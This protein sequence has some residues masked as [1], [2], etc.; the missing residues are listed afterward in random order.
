MS[1]N[2]PWLNPYQRSYQSIKQTLIEK[3]QTRVPEITDLSEGNIFMVIISIWAAMAEVIHYYI[4]NAARESFFITARRY[5]SLYKHAKLVDYHIK[6]GIPATV[7]VI[8]YRPNNLPIT[9]NLTIPLD[10]KFNSSDG[11]SWMVTKEITWLANTYTVKIPLIQKS[12]ISENFIDLGIITSEN[13]QVLIKDIPSGAF[14]A[15]G[16][17]ILK[18]NDEP[19]VLVDTFAYA[20]SYDKVFKVELDELLKPIIVFGDGKFGMKPP[21]GSTL[22]CQYYITYGAGG[23]I[24]E[25]NFT[26]VPS[27]LTGF[28]NDLKITNTSPATGGTNYEDFDALKEHIPLSIKTL[29]VA[30]TKEDYEAISR[31]V[32]GVSKAYVNYI[33][34]RF[35]EIYI[36]P[37]NGGEASQALMDIAYNIISKSKVIT[38]SVTIKSTKSAQIYI[39]ADVTGKKSFKSSDISNQ[40]NMALL[41]AYNYN[42]S[43][44]NKPVRLSDLYALMDK[45]TMV[46]FLKIKNLYFLP[47]IE[48][49]N[50][51]QPTLIMSGYKQLAF[52]VSQAGYLN[53]EIGLTILS[54]TQYTIKSNIGPVYTGTYG[55][56]LTVE[57][58]FCKFEITISNDNV[59]Y[60][61]GDIYKLTI[62]NM[63]DDLTPNNYSIPIFNVNNIILNVH[64]TL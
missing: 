25:N 56:P 64:E 48:P 41:E 49:K 8:L 35:V 36:T 26:T 16:S 63:N 34:G 17:M 60:N 37:D 58:A 51:S 9:S 11:K 10:L 40:L 57:S 7:D 13:I 14:Y 42:T 61:L 20:N 21:V 28:V 46:D 19:W 55:Q 5:S 50:I 53:E 33:C 12:K 3:L 24:L 62:Q 18:V 43:D 39:E 45:Q 23:N 38:T 52:N 1:T 27:Y 4:D 30:I 59:S 2:N 44:I 6:S 32:P 47:T 54:A 15:E 29:G 31:L 22:A